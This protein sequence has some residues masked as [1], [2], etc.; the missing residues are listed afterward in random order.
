MLKNF[1]N[2][3]K[4]IFFTKS[5]C[6]PF[7]VNEWNEELSQCNSIL[8]LRQDRIG[9]LLVSV[10]FI[11]NLRRLLPK[12]E[13][14]L[15]LSQRNSV[16]SACVHNYINN[17]YV[18]PKNPLFAFFFVIKLRNHFDL[19]IDLFDNASVT[20][21]IL[22]RFLKSKYS[23][24][25]DKE[26]SS[27]YSHI[28]RLPDKGQ[29]HI[30]ERLANLLLPFGGKPKQIELDLEYPI[31]EQNLLPPKHKPRLGINI[32]GSSYSKYWGRSNFFQLIKLIQ[33]NFDF[34]ICIFSTPKYKNEIEFFKNKLSVQIAPYT[35]NFDEF[36]N[37]IA[38]CDYLITPDTSVVHLASAFKIP[39][40]AYYQYLDSKFGIPWF[41]YQ[42]KFQYLTSS[43]NY[44][45]DITP[46]QMFKSFCQL[47]YEE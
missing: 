42:T 45:S 32:S 1:K 13:I 36:A 37:M 47:I 23:L 43:L 17:F 33:S 12:A 40:L 9:D 46:E 3:I 39:I 2:F 21:S 19:V 35:K 34:D 28:V 30:V 5:K 29:I 44:F 14:Y 16:A 8:I 7:L 22:V 6:K 4:P 18:L 38:T 20:S 26:N 11:R 24:G 10:P 41:P 31:S 25:F 27:L 15:L